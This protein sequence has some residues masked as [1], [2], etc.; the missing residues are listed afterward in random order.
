MA[1]ARL[2]GDPNDKGGVG[3]PRDV[4]TG[5]KLHLYGQPVLCR[6]PGPCAS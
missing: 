6:S 5:P 2:P 1:S 3:P 4:V